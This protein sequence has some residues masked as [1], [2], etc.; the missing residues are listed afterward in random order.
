MGPHQNGKLFSHESLSEAT[1]GEKIFANKVTDKGLLFETHKQ[2]MQF[3][4]KKKKNPN[5]KMGRRLKQTLSN[6][7]LQ[8]T[9]K[10][11]KR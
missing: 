4:I 9:K 3:N 7:D 8:M 10:H 6:E 11:M 5:Q 1:D 2:F